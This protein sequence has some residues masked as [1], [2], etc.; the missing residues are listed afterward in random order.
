MP[1]MPTCTTLTPDLR[2]HSRDIVQ[3]NLRPP[4]LISSS[5]SFA[6]GLESVWSSYRITGPAVFRLPVTCVWWGKNPSC[7]RDLKF[8]CGCLQNMKSTAV[9]GLA[10]A[11]F[12]V[13]L[14]PEFPTDVCSRVLRPELLSALR[15]LA[16]RCAGPVT[17]IMTAVSKLWTL[18]LPSQSPQRSGHGREPD[19]GASH[20]NLVNKEFYV[21]T[22]SP[23]WVFESLHFQSSLKAPLLHFQQWATGPRRHEKNSTSF[24]F[25]LLLWQVNYINT[26]AHKLFFC[27]RCQWWS[28]INKERV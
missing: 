10:Y 9:F 26:C 27:P 22:R 20:V 21:K 4:P 14:R 7:R 2:T 12:W 16:V 15:P 5:Y 23:A 13:R 18:P 25:F 19:R 11:D 28:L 6:C 17:H 3:V 8:H 1:Q 24:Q